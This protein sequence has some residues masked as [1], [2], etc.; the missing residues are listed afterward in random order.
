M[1]FQ[2][3]LTYFVIAFIA[4]G[5]MLL[6][7]GVLFAI[8]QTRRAVSLAAAEAAR[9]ADLSFTLVR[10]EG[11]KECFDASVLPKALTQ[12]GAVKITSEKTLSNLSEEGKS[13]L[14]QYAPTR[15]PMVI[16]KGE[17]KK[18]LEKLPSFETLGEQKN[19][20]L[21][22]TKFPPPYLDLKT[23][24]VKGLLTLTYL[25]EKRCEEC[26]EVT[27]HKAILGNLGLN[28]SKE[29]IV[30]QA[31][32]QGKQLIARY[33]IAKLPTIIIQGDTDEYPVLR[34]VWDAVGTVA[35]DGAFVFRTTESMGTYFDLKQGKA[36]IKK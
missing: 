23:G 28:P 29:E 26:Y 25:I 1:I 14:N 4:L 30:D 5:F 31:D 3:R 11:C 6:N 7:A 32:A 10:D 21:L 36:I 34:Q 13:L 16:I 20:A 19:E 17:I 15:L 9:P 33:A 35:K 22:I 18:A 8:Q 2:G 12:S 24:A 27:S